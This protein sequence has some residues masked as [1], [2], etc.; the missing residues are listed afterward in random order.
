MNKS[1]LDLKSTFLFLNF[2]ISNSSFFFPYK[3]TFH[4]E[5]FTRRLSGPWA[6]KIPFRCK[7]S[8][9]IRIRV[10]PPSIMFP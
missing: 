9:S 2:E 8:R 1:E 3:N 6:A 10:G 4:F 7:I 5:I